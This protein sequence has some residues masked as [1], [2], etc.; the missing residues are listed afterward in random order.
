[1]REELLEHDWWKEVKAFPLVHLKVR[2]GCYTPFVALLGCGG[3]TH[4]ACM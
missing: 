4:S 1:M 3:L 2:S